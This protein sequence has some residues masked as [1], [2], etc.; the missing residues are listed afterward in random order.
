MCGIAGRLNFDRKPVKSSEIRTMC[1]AIRHRG[2][3]D[4]G[5]WV[6]GQVGLGNRRLSII[7]LSKAGRQPIYNEDKSV[8]V[9]F[10]G[11]VYNFQELRRGLI[12]KG[13]KFIQ[14]PTQRRLCIF[15]KNM[16]WNALSS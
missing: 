8:W 1:Q 12:R 3:D 16:G 6:K 11:E 10:N 2:P 13:H 15:G 4:Q 7:D 14:K 9:T 5:V